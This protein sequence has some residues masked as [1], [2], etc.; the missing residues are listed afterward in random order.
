[1]LPLIVVTT[2][3]A[4]AEWSV[5]A[6]ASLDYDTNLSR[7][8]ASS[9]VRAD[10]AGLAALAVRSLLAP[11]EYDLL[12][13]A[14]EAGGE[15]YAR[16]RGLDNAWLGMRVAYRHKAGLGHS[17][18]WVSLEAAAAYHEYRVDVRT[19]SRFV[20]RAVAA[21]RFGEVL[22]TY[23]EVF[24]DERRGPYGEAVDANVSGRVFDLSGWG[25]GAGVAYA[26]N[27]TVTISARGSVR[28]GDVVSTASESSPLLASATAIA[29]DPTFGEELYD[30]R[31]RGTTCLL[32]FAASYA[33]TGRA[34]LTLAYTAERT[35][36]A[37]GLDYRSRAAGV[38]FLYRY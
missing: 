31:L 12:V 18:P 11:T 9:D 29:E 10:A 14:G 20:L 17:A 16:Y 5:D 30:Y 38:T 19:G 1:M 27:D 26:L 36:V 34:S 25:G 7:A 21:R 28:S 15:H 32:S 2:A 3:S 4:R 8:V 13:L 33:L 6:T 22:D 35:G 37:H 23:A 24:A